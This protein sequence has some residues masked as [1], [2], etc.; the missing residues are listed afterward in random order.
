MFRE[1]YWR[2]DMTMKRLSLGLCLM[3]LGLPTLSHA[4]SSKVQDTKAA[5]HYFE[6]ELN[7]TT[8]P[9]GVKSAIEEAAKGKSKNIIIVDLR[10]EE[11]Y[12]A[13]HIPGAINLPY[14]KWEVFKGDHKE[15]PGLRKDTI[16]YVYCYQ[17]LCNLGQLAG[18]KFASLG[19]PVKEMRGGFQAWKEQKYPIEQ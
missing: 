13:G 17:L 10:R 12:K 6:N 19:Y 1:S 4:K 18:K 16:N 3:A 15:F 2:K 14:D 7:F 11:D 5:M 9:M 8:N